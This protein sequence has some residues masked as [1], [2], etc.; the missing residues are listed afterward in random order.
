MLS[1]AFL[2]IA[3][4]DFAI[5]VW[6]VK[7]C[8]Q[9]RTNGL[10]FATIPLTLLWYDNVVIGIGGTLGQGDLL[11]GLNYVRF[12]AHYIALPMTFIALGA[13]AREAQFEWARKSWVM[14]TYCLIAV[15]FIVMDLVKFSGQEFYPSCFADTLRYTT[16][17]TE[18]TRC[19]PDAALVGQGIPPIPALT[20]TVFNI[21]F[22]ILLWIK[23]GWPWLVVAA[24][25]AMAF[26]A[27]PYSKTGGIFS[28]TGEPIITAVIILT[29][30]HI[31][32]RYVHAAAD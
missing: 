24:V 8:L 10:I 18:F 3:V 23:R 25:G 26:F 30:G 17:V 32:R 6:A 16:R 28:N 12:Y 22:G 11:I 19:T 9:Y 4:I 20:L 1:I 27:V 7:L 29:A 31:A 5:L 15:F 21:G 2:V 13:M 14:G